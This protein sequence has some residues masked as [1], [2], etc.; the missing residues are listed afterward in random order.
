MKIFLVCNQLGGVIFTILRKT[1]EE[2]YE[3][4]IRRNNGEFLVELDEEAIRNIKKL[5]KSIKGSFDNMKR[6]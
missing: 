6:L 5:E 1:F 2:A 4:S 3:D